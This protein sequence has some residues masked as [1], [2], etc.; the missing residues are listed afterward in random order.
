[1]KLKTQNVFLFS[2]CFS[3]TL[4]HSYVKVLWLKNE[5]RVKNIFHLLFYR[6]NKNAKKIFMVCSFQ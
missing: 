4:K 3:I 1:M 6:K 5:I 2:K